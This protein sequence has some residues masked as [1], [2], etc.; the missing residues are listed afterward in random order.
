MTEQPDV[1]CSG[2]L[3]TSQL[4]SLP[5]TAARTRVMRGPS[6]GMEWEMWR[7]T[8]P[9]ALG[10]AVIEL[11]AG[12]EPGSPAR[13]RV[14]PNGEV[15][16]MLQI[17]A[18]QRLVEHDGV[19][20]DTMLKGAI[21][22]GLQERPGTFESTAPM[23]VVSAR[24]TPLGAWIV[25]GGVPQ[26]ELAQRVLSIDD[27]LPACA[28]MSELSER[29]LE[30]S[31][32]GEG[33]DLLE[34]WLLARMLSGDAPQPHAATQLATACLQTQPQLSIAAIAKTCGV[35]GRRLHELF[36]RE[37]GLSPKRLA[38]ILRFRRALQMLAGAAHGDLRDVALSCGYYDQPHLYRDFRAL[39]HLT[40]IEYM[41]KLGAGLDGADVLPG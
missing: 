22:S 9:P 5:S 13:H 7:R 23:S 19:K 30:V 15:S 14:L 41:A 1:V 34:H 11:W 2:P 16:L 8:P 21:V 6:P 18:A 3:M 17:G 36:L 38:R 25:L 32:L 20:H 39:A 24:L 33:L 28:G 40:P 4:H 37:V 29:L 31:D 35:S 10:G 26:G 12:F 27:V